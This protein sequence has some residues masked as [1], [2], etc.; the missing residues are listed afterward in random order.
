MNAEARDTHTTECFFPDEGDRTR[1]AHLLRYRT[2]EEMT[3]KG[4]VLSLP[5]GVFQDS[6]MELAA[7][8][9]AID[10]QEQEVIVGELLG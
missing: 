8:F 6:D 1:L 5:A 9:D 4:H 2:A 7:D 10:P 3:L